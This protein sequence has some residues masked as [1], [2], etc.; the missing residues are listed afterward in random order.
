MALVQ[1]VL[2]LARLDINDTSTNTAAYRTPDAELLKYFNDGLARTLTIRPDLNF[3]NY[4]TSFVELTA[5][6]TFPL[7]LEYR[8]PLAAYV[9]ARQQTGDDA[10]VL[11]QRAD[12]EM[13]RYMRELGLG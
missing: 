2:D 4:G 9:V 7:A 3:G 8:A 12:L 13:V 5:T 1:S 10:N 11:S 6:S